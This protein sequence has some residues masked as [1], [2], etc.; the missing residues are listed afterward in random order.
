MKP[1]RSYIFNAGLPR[2]GST[3]L[4]AIL[5][6]NPSIHAAVSSPVCSLMR[7]TE[8][9]LEGD[10]ATA[11]SK[12][13]V[14]QRL[15]SE[16]P[17]TYYSDRAE[18]VIVDKSRDWLGSIDL[19]KRHITSAPKIICTVRHPVEI[20]ASFIEV[21]E[22]SSAVSQIDQALIAA[23]IAPTTRTRCDALLCRIG[24]VGISL[25]SLEKA[26][27][28]GNGEFI[29]FIDYDN[30]IDAP[31]AE[32]RSLYGFLGLDPFSHDFDNIAVSAPSN[33]AE[34]YGIVGLHTIRRSLGKRL[35]NAGDVLPSKVF[36]EL[37]GYRLP[38]LQ[39]VEPEFA[40]S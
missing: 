30:L 39:A 32:M 20:V 1:E 36:E 3:L 16:I 31:V 24:P 40:A 9:I 17:E 12:P 5:N 13:G 28:A 10:D 15:V 14:H 2:S 19:I 33:D 34:A 4:S 23:K 29:H 25:S 38:W 35:R 21:I 6:Q 11:C 8:S 26:L 18:P 27:T 37:S 22:R 7:G